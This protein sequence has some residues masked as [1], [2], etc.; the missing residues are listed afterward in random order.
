MAA[1][2]GTGSTRS[3]A[4]LVEYFEY[5]NYFSNAGFN[6]QG[7]SAYVGWS[8]VFSGLH[9][10]LTHADYASFGNL[11]AYLRLGL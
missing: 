11:I 7:A 8:F 4:V 1:G 2:A 10:T 5:L 6:F 3:P 9:V